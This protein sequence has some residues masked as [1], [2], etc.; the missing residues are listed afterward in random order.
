MALAYWA[1]EANIT[2][3]IPAINKVDFFMI[4]FPSKFRAQVLLSSFS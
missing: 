3:T 4:G 2:T 1:S